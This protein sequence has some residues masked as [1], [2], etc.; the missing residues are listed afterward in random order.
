MTIRLTY[1]NTETGQ[2]ETAE[3][4]D[5]DWVLLAGKSSDIVQAMAYGIGAYNGMM[6]EFR[7]F[8]LAGQAFDALCAPDGPLVFG[9]LTEAQREEAHVALLRA[10]LTFDGYLSTVLAGLPE[11]RRAQAWELAGELGLLPE[12]EPDGSSTGHP[13]H[14]RVCWTCG[15]RSARPIPPPDGYCCGVRWCEAT[16]GHDLEG[17]WTIPVTL[18]CRRC[19]QWSPTVSADYHGPTV[20]ALNEG[21]ATTGCGL[22]VVVDGRNVLDATNFQPLVNCPDCLRAEP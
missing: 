15:G 12:P 21:T 11:E 2:T 6:R 16:G 10:S 22:A 20:H 8:E 14:P 13:R 17:D 1:E 5:N 7:C 19:G 9:P 18:V 3:L 4:P